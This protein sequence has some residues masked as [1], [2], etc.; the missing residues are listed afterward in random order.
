VELN[1]MGYVVREL[2]RTYEGRLADLVHTSEH[3]Q[4]LLKM[5]L[6]EDLL[7]CAQLGTSTLLPK[8]VEGQ[9]LL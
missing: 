3:G 6:H 2:Y 7:F 4:S 5:G 8:F 9:V 1:D